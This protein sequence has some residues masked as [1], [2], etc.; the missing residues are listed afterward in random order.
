M[1]ATLAAARLAPSVIPYCGTPP[2]P[3]AFCC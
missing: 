3:A 2:D 1:T